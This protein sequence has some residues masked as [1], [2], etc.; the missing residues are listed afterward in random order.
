MLRMSLLHVITI[1]K[2]D[3]MKKLDTICTHPLADYA[4]SESGVTS[5]VYPSTAYNYLDSEELLYPGF[6]STYNQK[7]LGEI[8]ARLED[9]V[10]GLA[11]NSGMAAIT[12]T[13]L[14][15]TKEGDHIIFFNELYGGTWKFATEE[16]IQRGISYTF[17]D[18][19]LDSLEACLQQN[20]RIVYLETPSNPLLSIIDLKEVSMW[21]KKNGIIAIIDNTFATPINQK[22][23]S[24]GIDIVIHSGT[25]YLGGHNDL[26][27]GAVVIGNLEHKEFIL[28]TAKL[29]GG[30]LAPFSCYQAERS[31]KTL[32][33]RVQRQNE[34]AYKI[35]HYLEEHPCVKKVYY[36][37]LES[38]TNHLIAKKQMSGYGG[39]V[40]FELD[41]NEEELKNFLGSLSIIQIALSLGGVESLVCIPAATSHSGLTID[42]RKAMGISETLIRFSV[43]IEN[44]EDL[45][46][47]LKFAL[48]TISK[49][50]V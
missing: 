4:I 43:G 30:S 48:N 8:V 20:T 14:S 27:F 23:I 3:L 17:S 44:V 42:Q 34:S 26:P 31:I 28:S 29:Y 1:L 49:Q 32:A 18:N 22:P 45:V 2:R 9:G 10:W 12:T 39:M 47:D 25:K 35:A 37:G 6:F 19:N 13:I 33:L 40:S 7:R 38:H 24:L 15:L 5:A 36:P 46:A 16:L 11:F 50:K 41:C 21:A